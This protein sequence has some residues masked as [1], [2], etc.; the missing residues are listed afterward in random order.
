MD[1]SEELLALKYMDVA[2]RGG[3]KV[4]PP[5]HFHLSRYTLIEQ[6]A[7]LIEQSCIL[8]KYLDAFLNKISTLVYQN[9][10]QK[11]NF[12]SFSGESCSQT[13]LIAH[14]IEYTYH[15]ANCINQLPF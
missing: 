10:L 12:Q 7:T 6:S 11:A 15:T 8:N 5:L 9:E 1:C 14:A 13:L 3:A 2:Q 4:L